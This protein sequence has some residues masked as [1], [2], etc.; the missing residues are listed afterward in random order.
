MAF[1]NLS[2]DKEST[3]FE[4][5]LRVRDN[6]KI[7][8]S[9]IFGI[10]KT[11]FIDNF[12][13]S[14][15]DDYLTIKINPVNYSVSPNEDIFELIKFDIA[16]QLLGLGIDFDSVQIDT[17]I[18]AQ[19]YLVN[20]FPST[21]EILVKNLIKLN[22]QVDSIV[23]PALLLKDKIEKFKNDSET[24]EEKE[25]E[26]FL[27]SFSLKKGTYR[28][29]NSITELITILI[30][31]LK[32]VNKEKEIILIIDDLDRIDPEHIFR[33]L[34]IFSAH[35]DYYS[36]V[37]KNKFDFDKVIL[38]CDVENIRQIFH[39]RYGFAT[40]FTGYLDKFYSNDIYYYN[41]KN[42]I[43]SNIDKFLESIDLDKSSDLK[44]LKISSIYKVELQFLLVTFIKANVLN[45]RLLQKLLAKPYD[46]VDYSISMGH[47]NRNVIHSKQNF[48]VIIF[49]FLIKLFGSSV[50]L[51]NA[52]HCVIE[53]NPLIGFEKYDSNYPQARIGSY[54]MFLDSEVNEF[55][56]DERIHIYTHTP[57]NLNF[58]YKVSGNPSDYRVYG[59]LLDVFKPLNN[60]SQIEDNSTNFQVKRLPYFQLL[61][62]AFLKFESM[63]INLAS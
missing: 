8:L 57:T 15:T 12:F 7:I 2:I 53:K 45:M 26:T 23:S 3:N 59:E 17:K 16:F 40:D 19:Y 34:N 25:L 39:N 61:H 22:R 60:T 50:D 51:K 6:N 9:G 63:K 41:F 52:L 28:E 62:L 4:E 11:Y 20:N 33:I 31:N 13:R 10:G 43:S 29:Q 38:V 21:V 55:L 56:K 44:N 42:I 1:K 58:K 49:E 48:C 27:Q 46:I 30:Q 54:V 35:L 14:K 24:D 32:N 5:H 47:S 37:S 36:F 18:A